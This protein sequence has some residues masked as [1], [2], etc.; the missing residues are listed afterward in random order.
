MSTN[1]PTG[2]D[3]YGTLIDNTDDVLAAH[4]NDRGD[5]IEAL[6][7]KVGVD[8]S[9]VTTT[10]D[11]KVNNFFATGRKVYLYENT[12]PTG[13]SI[14]AVTDKVLAVKGGEYGATGGTTVGTWTQPSHTHTGPS[15]THT[16][17]S[18]AHTGPSHSHKW[19][20]FIASSSGARDGAGTEL[21]QVDRVG[22]VQVTTSG[23]YVLTADYYTS[24]DGTGITGAA[25]TGATGAA[26]T[27]NTGAAGTGATYRPYAAVGIIVT[28]T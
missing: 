23:T 19:Y 8:S 18:H 28:K 12:A 10:L 2:L 22:G 14:V 24:S 20:D 6:E 5:A 26:G 21:T 17:P 4:A 27:G 9:A 13:W 25:G 7:A 15:H 16:G 11:Y 1:F 3:S